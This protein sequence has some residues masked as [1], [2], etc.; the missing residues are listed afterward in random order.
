MTDEHESFSHFIKA[1]ENCK[2][3]QCKF[4]GIDS[5]KIKKKL[6]KNSTGS[7]KR[8][9]TIHWSTIIIFPILILFFAF[10]VWGFGELVSFNF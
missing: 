8:N 2:T 6:K 3:Y 10:G 1:F 5:Q 4:N 9:A 7:W